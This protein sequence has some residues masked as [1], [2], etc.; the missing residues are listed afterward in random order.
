MMLKRDFGST[1]DHR[2]CQIILFLVSIEMEINL[3]DVN[4][5]IIYLNY[6]N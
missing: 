4:I 5:F 6:N 3:I 1:I 2:N